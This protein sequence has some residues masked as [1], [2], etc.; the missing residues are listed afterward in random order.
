MGMLRGRPD[1][2]D[3]RRFQM[4]Q[5]LAS[6]GDDFWIEDGKRASVRD[7]F[8]LKDASGREV[9]K[10]QERKVS[11]RDKIAI[12]R[13]DRTPAT[14]RQAL[15]GTRDRFAIDVEDGED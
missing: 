8:V 13:D 10:I 14:V 1:D 9:A 15:V 6:I 2:Q 11:V 7:T 5:K 3:V 12:E 4:R